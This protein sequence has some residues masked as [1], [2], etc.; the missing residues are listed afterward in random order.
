MSNLTSKDFSPQIRAKVAAADR[1]M[2]ESHLANPRLPDMAAAAGCSVEHLCRIYR[3]VTGRTVYARLTELRIEAA[4]RLL[5]EG[6]SAKEIALRLKFCNRTHF[7][8]RFRASTGASPT[9]WLKSERQR[10]VMPSPSAS[11][12]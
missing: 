4:K 2:N 7:V 8:M 3:R 11:S 6:R 1:L 12:A 5:S 9:Q 10:S